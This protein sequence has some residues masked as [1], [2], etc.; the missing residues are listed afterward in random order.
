MIDK[1]EISKIF[2]LIFHESLFQKNKNLYIWKDIIQDY[3]KVFTI[4]FYLIWLRRKSKKLIDKIEISKIVFLIFHESL[5][6]KNKN[7]YF[8]KDIVQDYSTVS[9]ILFYLIWLQIK[10]KKLIDK[11][12]ISKIVFLIF[13]ESLF[14]KNKNLYFCKD[15][16]QDYSKVF[17]NLFYLIWLRIKSKKLIDKIE[18]SK[19]FFLIFHES[20]F[21]KNKNLYIWK[22]SSRTILKYLPFCSILFGYGGNQKN[23][24]TKLKFPKLFSSYFMKACSK[25]IKIYIFAKISSRTI[26]KYLPY[27]ISLRIKSKKLIDK[28][29]ISKIVFLI[30]HESVLTI[31]FDFI[32]FGFYN[33]YFPDG[34]FCCCP[35]HHNYSATQNEQKKLHQRIDKIEI[36]KIDFSSYFMKACSK[37]I[38]IY[39]FAKISSRTIQKSA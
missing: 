9:T 14:Q 29:E 2:F 20:L 35:L 19:I 23:W 26:L 8:C 15:I 21:Q 4:L 33:E 17:T 6:Q 30:F 24:L 7:L 25:K 12:E 13:H 28:I 11:I 3:S 16:V 5:F 1:I 34:L 38:K 31:L 18:I 37:K 22:I 32:L 39:I 36:S 10:S 27:L